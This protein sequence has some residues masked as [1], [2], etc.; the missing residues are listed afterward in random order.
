MYK[1]GIWG[2]GTMTFTN[3]YAKPLGKTMDDWLG[4]SGGR[5]WVSKNGET[6]SDFIFRILMDM[7]GEGA[8]ITD[9][10]LETIR[11]SRIRRR[12]HKS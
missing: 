7:E 10:L 4:S 11:E 6:P 12:K 9:Y 2:K 3:K 1:N 8:A 5:K